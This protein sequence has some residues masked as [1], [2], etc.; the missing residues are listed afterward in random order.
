MA[1]NRASLK[2]YGLNELRGAV[3]SYG[4]QVV[5]DARRTAEAIA[6]R[7]EAAMKADAPVKTGELRDS[8][9]VAVR[10]DMHGAAVVARARAPHA[11]FPEFG[12]EDTDK[13]PFFFAHIIRARREMA[14]A[15]RASV[16]A[17]APAGLGRPTVSGD[18]GGLPA[19]GSD[20]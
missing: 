2:I 5:E 4:R 18:V 1:G 7:T 8:I 15:Q 14:E 13:A 6:S 16:I 17:R 10:Y 11:S 20:A 9:S 3:Q 12:T 19:I